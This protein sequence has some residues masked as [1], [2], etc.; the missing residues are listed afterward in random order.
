MCKIEGTYLGYIDFDGERLWDYQ[1]FAPY[2]IMMQEKNTL[3]SDHMKR[4][5]LIN[6]RKGDVE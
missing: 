1:Q 2:K 5:D 4:A 6:L 3:K